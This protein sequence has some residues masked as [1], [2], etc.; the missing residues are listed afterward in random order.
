MSAKRL[1][2]STIGITGT[3][4]ALYYTACGVTGWS[5]PA[6]WGFLIGVGMALCGVAAAVVFDELLYRRRRR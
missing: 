4:L 6:E 3:L 1:V 5:P 2:L